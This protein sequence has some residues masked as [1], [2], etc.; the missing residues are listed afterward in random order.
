M[1]KFEITWLEDRSDE[2]ILNEIRRV[3]ALEPGRRL[4]VDRFNA[5]AR[6]KSTAVRDRFGSWSEATRRAG[7]SNALPIYTQDAIIEDLQRASAL[8][9]DEPFTISVYSR[10]GRYS[11]SCITRQFGG[12]REALDR[13]GL[14]TRYVGPEITERMK[15]QAGRAMSD[16]E[17]LQRIRDVAE[18]LG[19]AQLSGA[20]IEANCEVTQSQMFR[21]FGSVSVALKQAGVEQVNHGRRYTED[22]IF[23]NLLNVWTHY[24]RSP[25][26]LEMDRPPST[27]GKNAY[28]RRYGGWRNALK[29]FVERA[30]SEAE[31]Y[32]PAVASHEAPSPRINPDSATR[33][34]IARINDTETQQSAGPI[35]MRSRPVR[36][37]PTNVQPEDRRDPSIGLRFKVLQRDRFKCVLCGDHPAR[38]AECVLHVDH[39]IP[40][41]KGGKTREDNLRT[42]CATCNVGRGNRFTD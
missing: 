29:A 1:A 34:S 22:E 11:A 38:N 18:Q 8:S 30:N 31:D 17:I 9:Q 32:P 42:L 5:V 13:A 23:E 2:A 37:T 27:V 33:S 25:T 36:P 41:S 24:G 3:A 6:I 26:A 40:W 39:V 10:S 4:T 35:A 21:R 7:L 14:N 15:S 16:D 19:K 28:I 20:E 12:W